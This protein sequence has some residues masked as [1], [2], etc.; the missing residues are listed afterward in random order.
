MFADKNSC[1]ESESFFPKVSHL[2]ITWRLYLF[3]NNLLQTVL[4]EISSTA[5]SFIFQS[6]EFPIPNLPFIDENIFFKQNVLS[7]HI[8]KRTHN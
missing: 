2:E 5:A 6:L 7:A 4:E 3:S 1:D 8:K